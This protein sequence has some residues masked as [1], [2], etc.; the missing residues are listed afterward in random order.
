MDSKALPSFLFFLFVSMPFF[1]RAQDAATLISDTSYYDK[2]WQ[3]CEAPNAYYT[4]VRFVDNEVFKVI[5]YYPN[6]KLQMKGSYKSLTPEVK[7]GLFQCF[8]EEDAKLESEGYYLNNKKTGVW[9]SYKDNDV[10]WTEQEFVEGKQHG[11]LKSYYDGTILRRLDYYEKDSFKKGNCY[12]REGKDT[13][14]F[15]FRE[16]PE[17][18][19]GLDELYKYLANNTRYPEEASKKSIQGKIMLQFLI[20]KEGLVSGIE[21]IKG[22]HPSLDKE[23]IRVISKMPRWKPGTIEGEPAD[24]FY[25]LPLKFTLK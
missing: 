12:T 25:K 21:V 18:Q 9:K 4:R 7:E 20:T 24:I 2:H 16:M 10:L 22:V 13:T 11:F 15:P 5:D 17:F 14:H 8:K 1:L 19:G 3:E 6:W 23:A